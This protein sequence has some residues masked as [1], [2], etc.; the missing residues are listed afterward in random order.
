MLNLID[1]DNKKYGVGHFDLIIIDECHRSIY[2][3]YQAIFHYFDALLLGLTATPKEDV[4]KSTYDIFD[5]EKGKPTYW[6]GLDTAVKEGFWLV[7][8]HL[9]ELR[10]F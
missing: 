2:N 8:G 6:Y 1:S 3:K 4:E 10:I 9:K 5:L 7:I